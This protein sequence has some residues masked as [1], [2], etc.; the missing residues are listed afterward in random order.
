MKI[1]LLSTTLA[2]GCFLSTSLMAT[3]FDAN[4]TSDVIFGSGNVNGGFTVDQSN[5][6]EIGLRGK[7]RY[8]LAGNPQNI[9]NSNGDGTYTFD[10]ADSVAPATRSAFNFEWSINSDFDGTSGFAL[11]DLT[12]LLSIDYDP[13][14]AIGSTVDF[15]PINI[16]FADHAFGNN[17]TGNGAGTQA[18]SLAGYTALISGSNLVQN[19]WNLGFFEPAGFDPQT[20]GFYTISLSAFDNGRQVSGTSI[21][22][23]FGDVPSPVPLPASLPLLLGAIGG[24]GL[25]RRRKKD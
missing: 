24:F 12:Y 2:L 11:N 5:G 19:S 21:G 17:T 15:D 9:F 4:V 7:L 3:T 10:P 16:P 1:T 6:V 18:V 13:T 8:D 14:I 25:L 23:Q 20:E 22:I